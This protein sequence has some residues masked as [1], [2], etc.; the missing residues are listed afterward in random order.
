MLTLNDDDLK[1]VIPI[2]LTYLINRYITNAE[3]EL[4][5]PKPIPL[6]ALSRSMRVAI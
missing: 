4:R 6:T 2:A 5:I 3:D 1:V